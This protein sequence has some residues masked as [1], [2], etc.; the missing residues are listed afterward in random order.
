[1]DHK[2]KLREVLK[3]FK[4]VDVFWYDIN[5]QEESWTPSADIK[6]NIVPC[7]VVTCGFIV[8]QDTHF[9]WIASSIN[10]SNDV[11]DSNIIPKGCII[12][13]VPSPLRDSRKLEWGEVE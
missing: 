6:D 3:K 12:A 13:I 11:C 5:P 1:V 4:K 10:S 7:L 2:A 8:H 9:L